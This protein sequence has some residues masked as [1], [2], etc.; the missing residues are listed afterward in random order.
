MMDRMAGYHG[1]E[2]ANR[3]SGVRHSHGPYWK[4]AH[5]DWRFW[6][7]LVL[8]LAAITIYALSDD[9]ALVPRGQ[10]PRPPP[11]AANQEKRP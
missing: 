4:R 2:G 7:G 8:M 6:V 1:N 10:P 11:G 3:E 9:L 5:H